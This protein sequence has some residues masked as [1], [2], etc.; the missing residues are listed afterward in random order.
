MRRPGEIAGALSRKAVSAMARPVGTTLA[1]ELAKW[2]LDINAS[3]P[4]SGTESRVEVTDFSIRLKKA[5]LTD[6][7]D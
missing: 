2:S 5:S 1:A 4:L 6:K 7:N 3:I